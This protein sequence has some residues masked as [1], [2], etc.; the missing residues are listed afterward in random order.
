MHVLI[1]GGTG[2]VG[3]A[4]TAELAARGHQVTI[5][6]R[7]PDKQ[8]DLPAGAAV[9]G[10]DGRTTEGW[11]HLMEDTDA[12]VNLAGVSIGGEDTWTIFTQ[13]WTDDYKSRI[14]NSRLQVGKA[15]TQAIKAATNKPE[16]LLQASAMGYYGPRGDEVLT[17][18]TPP[19]QDFQAGVCVAWEDS[20]MAVEAMG[21]RRVITRTGLVMSL[22][23]GILPVMLLPFRLFVGGPLG[24]GQQ[25]VS[26][27][28]L[29]DEVAA[30]I[31]LLENE[32]ATGAYN[33]SAPN[34][35][36]YN[37][38][39]RVAGRVLRRPSFFPVPSFAL[40][41]VLGEKSTLVLGSLRLHPQRLLDAGYDF[42]FTEMEPA[43]RDLVDQK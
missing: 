29:R 10:W 40:K 13:R 32:S 21:V 36:T 31:F 22:E 1:T 19:G 35:L 37:Q 6:T 5:L 16:M 9:A 30:M 20:T 12:V 18:A 24:N 33:L 14:L 15:V 2:L 7:S 3:R 17:E 23:G 25:Y 11:G 41:L 27:I 43:L 4:L 8:R 39:R 34:P 28:H 26:W 38:F 42:H